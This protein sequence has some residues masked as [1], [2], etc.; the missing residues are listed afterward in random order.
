AKIPFPQ[1]GITNRLLGNTTEAQA[2]QEALR[3]AEQKEIIVTN[4]QWRKEGNPISETTVGKE[5][6]IYADVHGA[7]ATEGSYIPLIIYEKDE[8]GIDDSVSS[9][10]GEI[11]N[12][13]INVLWI[14]IYIQDNDDTESAQELQEQEYTLPEYVVKYDNPDGETVESELLTIKDQL[15]LKVMNSET[16]EPLANANYTI[17]L[18]DGDMIEGQLDAD[19][20]AIVEECSASRNY[21]IVFSVN[22]TVITTAK[23]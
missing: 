18:P 2:N 21:P 6:T 14:T 8:Q 4:L 13:R 9:V 10:I 20:Y 17:A 5:V 12:N 1:I 7:D 16:E 15:E 19:G 3:E 11:K 23:Y 22:G